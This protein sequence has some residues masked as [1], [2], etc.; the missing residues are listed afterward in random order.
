MQDR[1]YKDSYYYVAIRTRISAARRNHFR[2][3][4]PPRI[5]SPLVQWHPA[6]ATT[7]LVE[8]DAASGAL[9]DH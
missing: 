1:P 8:V 6:A 9:E 4:E 3:I 7:G 2:V 5:R